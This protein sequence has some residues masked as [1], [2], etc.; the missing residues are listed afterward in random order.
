MNVWK[1]RKSRFY[2][3]R[4]VYK[5]ELYERSTGT[6]NRRE[7]LDLAV[8]ARNKIIRQLAGLEQP[9]SSP[10]IKEALFVTTLR[11]FQPIFDAWV[12]TAK[13]EQQGTVKFY[14]DNYR[15]LLQF[16][17]W[18]N[19]RLDEID[20]PQI[21]AFKAWALK[22]GPS[23]DRKSYPGHQNHREQISGDATQGVALWHRKLKL[24]ER[25][26]VI[27]Q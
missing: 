13:K 17:P 2:Y 26:P 9:E 5:G 1:R 7:A 21:E 27:E 4:F 12:G 11:E 6:T 22:H 20:E 23:Q 16:G 25:V 18:T 10:P 14:R 15:K 3:Y 19:L 8:A 24:I